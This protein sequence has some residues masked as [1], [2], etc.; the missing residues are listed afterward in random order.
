[1]RGREQGLCPRR[2]EQ[3]TPANAALQEGLGRVAPPGFP[4]PPG[5]ARVSTTL[6][7][8]VLE[9]GLGAR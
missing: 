9:P 3:G 5:L 7:W 8:W 1:M 4:I 6:R 2:G